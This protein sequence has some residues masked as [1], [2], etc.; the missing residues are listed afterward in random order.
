MQMK[1][2]MKTR[3]QAKKLGLALTSLAL[4][5]LTLAAV[6]FLTAV[7]GAEPVLAD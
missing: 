6:F 7:S 2:K 5:A 3:T 1:T 4:A